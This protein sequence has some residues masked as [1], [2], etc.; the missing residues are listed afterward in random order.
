M[1]WGGAEWKW[2]ASQGASG[3]VKM[4]DDDCL[5]P[6]FGSGDEEKQMR[7]LCFEDRIKGLDEYW[8]RGDRS[9][10]MQTGSCI[11]QR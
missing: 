11:K 6:D 9:P 2:G 7:E 4:Q 8:V 1:G 10:P 5:D 3:G